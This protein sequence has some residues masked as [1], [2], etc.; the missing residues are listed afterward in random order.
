MASASPPPMDIVLTH[1]AVY[2]GVLF[3]TFLQG[4]LTV[5]AYVY[6]E[7]FPE[8]KPWLKSLVA[9]VWTIDFA[10]L[11]L[12]AYVP[13]HALVIN[14]GNP[15]IFFSPN[16]VLSMQIL[17][18]GLPTLLC[19]MFFLRR[20]WLFSKKNIYLISLLGPGS[21]TVFA[22]DFFLAIQTTRSATAYLRDTAELSAMFGLG[23][24]TDLCIALALVY[25][26]RRGVSDMA[27]T[28]HVI[29]KVIRYTVATGLLSSWLA[30]FSL[31]ANVLKPQAF[32]FMA[33]HLC[34]GRMYTNA[35]L[36]TLNARGT[37]RQTLDKPVTNLKSSL[38]FAVGQRS[39]AVESHS[40]NAIVPVNDS[41]GDGKEEMD[42]IV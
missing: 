30:I 24:A 11:I 18:I 8:D 6:Y 34:L 22:L 29:S 38:V 27:A 25:Y 14:W 28:N 4:I 5:Q 3:A 13:W 39:E 17:L 10:H 37:L 15:A 19:Q 21:V 33:G 7:R 12:V 35:L 2:I 20:L 23:A 41:G 42:R 40:L 16:N 32:I 31:I 26:L 9:V 36:A 1:G